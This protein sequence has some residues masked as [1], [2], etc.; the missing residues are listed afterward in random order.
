MDKME[1]QDK[2]AKISKLAAWSI[3]CFIVAIILGIIGRLF[4]NEI[5]VVFIIV[6]LGLMLGSGICAISGLVEIVRSKWRLK[7]IVRCIISILLLILIS[8]FG[9]YEHKKIVFEIK[10]DLINKWRYLPYRKCNGASGVLHW[11]L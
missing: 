2:K 7:G 5:G 6:T 11:S 4:D 3:I 10:R 8:I 1:S 9:W